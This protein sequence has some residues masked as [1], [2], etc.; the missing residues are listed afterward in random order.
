MRPVIHLPPMRRLLDAA[1]LLLA[2]VTA[3]VWIARMALRGKIRTD[4]GG[5]LGFAAELAPPSPQRPRVLLFGVSVGE[6]NAMRQLVDDLEADTQPVIAATTD[7]GFA[8][9]RAL[10]GD[11]FTVVRWP[12]DFS[13]AVDRF[14]GRVRPTL[15]VLMELE[16]WPGMTRSCTERGIPIGVINGRLSSR[17]FVRYR[18]IARLIRPAFSRLSFAAVQ[19]PEYARRFQAMGVPDSRLSVTGT[20][21]WDTARI[22]DV[23][24]GADQL[25]GDLGID[26]SRPLVVAGS[27]AGEEHALL[28]SAVPDGV[29]LLCA[30]RRPEAFD[31]AARTLAPCVRRTQRVRSAAEPG[32]HAL[33]AA[34]ADRF[35]LD[36]IGELRQAYALADLVVVGRTFGNLH[37]SDM[38]EPVALGKA[39]I[40]GPAVG[41]FQEA[42]DTLLA[43]GGLMQT[44]ADELPLAVRTLLADR[45][46][47]RAMAERGR[48]VIR[49]NQGASRAHAALIR[50]QLAELLS[51][52]N[53]APLIH[54]SSP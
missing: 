43:A 5:R 6:I 3:P 15:V 11:R 25:A 35:L 2:I 40:I 37:G 52:K 33:S 26:R 10:F 18:R 13:F 50:A 24:E 42:A 30:P 41:D 17:S 23:V 21:K 53:S 32:N 34:G 44:T 36:T 8:R 54:P 46:A 51:E 27:T 38:M 47:A 16:V 31:D 48:A 45:D 14:L 20:M 28:R 1:L 29:Q 9:A 19:T 7:T 39:V 12:L 22:T 49:S 4:W